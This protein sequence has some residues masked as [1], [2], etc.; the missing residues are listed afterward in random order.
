MNEAAAH[1]AALG[2]LAASM[3]ITIDELR[4]RVDSPPIAAPTVAEHVTAYLAR[5]GPSTRETYSTH[6]L[7]MVRGV[8][9]VCDQLCA[10][11]LERRLPRLEIDGSRVEDYVC[12][13]A[14]KACMS[15]RITIPAM[16]ERT[17]GP[18][19]YTKDLVHDLSVVARRYAIK[20]GVVDN[21]KRATRGLPMKKGDGHNAAETAVAAMRSLYATASAHLA[22][23]NPAHEIRK[24]RRDPKERRPLQMFELAELHLVTAT[25]GNDSELD[26]LI[27]DTGIATGARAKGIAELTIGQLCSDTQMIKIRDKGGRLIDMPV[28]RELL[29]RLSRH[30]ISRAGDACN[31]RSASYIPDTPVFRLKNGRAMSERRLDSLA[32]RW[33]GSLE[34]ARDEQVGFHHIRHTISA[35]LGQIG[36]QYKKRYLRHADNSVTDIYGKVPLDAFAAVMAELLGFEHPLVHGIEDRRPTTL[37]RLGLDQVDI[38][39]R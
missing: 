9:P 39:R 24:P 15:S 35:L 23:R 6:L 12:G 32:Q 28:S 34:W 36:P 29:D 2:A 4:R 19:T 22:G 14:C 5:L 16:G 20:S 38:G 37:R 18:D 21:R 11:C 3:G 31:P 1:D 25:G 8:G 26:V 10:P 13:C 30:T 33:Q 27:L 17:V 7:R